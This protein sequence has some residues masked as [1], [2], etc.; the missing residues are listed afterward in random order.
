MFEGTILLRHRAGQRQASNE[1]HLRHGHDESERLLAVSPEST[2][3]V[4]STAEPMIVGTLS[5]NPC[6]AT[7]PLIGPAEFE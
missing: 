1:A 6:P 2:F 7:S 5:F 4:G 3:D